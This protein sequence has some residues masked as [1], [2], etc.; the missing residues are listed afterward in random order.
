MLH[1]RTGSL[2]LPTFGGGRFDG[3]EVDILKRL[4]QQLS[5]RRR[6]FDILVC[7]HLLGDAISFLGVDD[8]VGVILRTEV[9]LEAQHDHRQDVAGLEST[10]DFFDPLPLII[11]EDDLPRT[12]VIGDNLLLSAC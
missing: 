12:R 9:S 7:S 10:A 11:N 4:V 6:A 2:R 5:R 3:C 8:A 1:H